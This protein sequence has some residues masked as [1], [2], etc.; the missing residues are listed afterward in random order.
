MDEVLATR[1]WSKSQGVASKRRDKKKW[2]RREWEEELKLLF[3]FHLSS[4]L[5]CQLGTAG[6]GKVGDCWAT[7]LKY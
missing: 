7:T 3:F 2:R 4:W 1:V 6:A 5:L